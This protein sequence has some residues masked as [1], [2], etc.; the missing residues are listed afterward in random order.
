VIIASK[1]RNKMCGAEDIREME[2]W[3]GDKNIKVQIKCHHCHLCPTFHSGQ[4]FSIILSLFKVSEIQISWIFRPSLQLHA[5]L[6]YCSYWL[7]AVVGC[8]QLLVVCTVGWCEYTAG[9]F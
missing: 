1:G 4:S 3:C 5:V 2:K 7:S 6:V 8:L 9:F